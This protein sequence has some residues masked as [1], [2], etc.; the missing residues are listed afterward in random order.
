MATL[1]LFFESC[2][3]FPSSQKIRSELNGYVYSQEGR[4][5][6]SGKIFSCLYSPSQPQQCK[7]MSQT[8]IHSDGSFH[9]SS[10]SQ[11]RM[12]VIFTQAPSE[13]NRIFY[14][15]PDGEPGIQSQEEREG[16]K[17]LKI[18]YPDPQKYR[19][20][21][22]DQKTYDYLHPKPGFLEL[23]YQYAY[24][25]FDKKLCERTLH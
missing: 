18:F 12:A 17:Y 2:T 22:E 5:L 15:Y 14:C 4:P 19:Q 1:F 8:S 10:Q 16:K 24:Y 23:Y 6:N 3:F 21:K 9:F 25:E 13:K 20:L 11:L 7:K